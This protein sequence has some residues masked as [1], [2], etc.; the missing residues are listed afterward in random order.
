MAGYPV[1]VPSINDVLEMNRKRGAAMAT[2]A[3]KT[4][5]RKLLERAAKDLARRI[6]A[7]TALRGGGAEPFTVVQ[8]RVTLKQV[9]AVLHPLQKGLLG[10]VSEQGRAAAEASAAGALD[11]L[12]VAEAR[13]RGV[14]SAP[15][16]LSEA[17]VL[18]AAVV[19]ADASVLRRLSGDPGK[20]GGILARYGG[21][22]IDDFEEELR[23]R[24]VQKTPWDEVRENITERSPFLQGKPAFWAERI[25]RTEVMGANNRA[26]VEVM[27]AADEELGD[28][29]KI[30]SCVFDARTGSDSI[31]VHG[32]IRRPDEPF[33][34][35][36][37]KFQHPPDR[38][39]DRAVVVPHRISWPI[40]AALEPMTDADVL[41][42]W[43][44][45]G[46]KGAPPPRPLDSTVDRTRFGRK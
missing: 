41:D 30:I 15:L 1:G 8:M 26:N 14:A 6:Q 16:P 35:W 9:E 18:D 44:E 46:R 11:Y 17:Q 10:M 21:N 4:P 37:G 24:F 33:D 39:N 27:R 36:F 7:A 20:G 31:A 3:G 13:Y 40:P 43:R 25:V 28:M 38:P 23:Q 22:V 42:R 32:Q 19:G 34:S 12:R 5:T 29:V 2:R 45:E